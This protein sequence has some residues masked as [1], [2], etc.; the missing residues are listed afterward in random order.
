MDLGMEYEILLLQLGSLSRKQ[1]HAQEALT[2]HEQQLEAII[3]QMEKEKLD[4]EK[5]ERE[6]LSTALRKLLGTFEKTYDRESQDL[7]RAKLE[8]DKAYALKVSV[9]R[10]LNELEAEIIEKKNRLRSVKETLLRRNPQLLT[11]G[12]R[13]DQALAKLEHEYTQIQEAEAAG[14][15]TLEAITDILVT[16]DSNDTITNWELITEIDLILNY[17]NKEQLNMAEAMILH[18]EK[19]VSVLERE[20]RDVDFL[21]EEQYATISSSKSVLD[22][23]LATIFQEWSKKAII[24]K[25]IHHLKEL[26]E[27]VLQVMNMLAER[28]RELEESFLE[29]QQ[30]EEAQQEGSA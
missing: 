25:S 8:F 15:Q 12:D 24:E 28:K 5:L 17:V 26:E 14:Y 19:C 29:M 6:S 21:Y 2:K 18:L 11:A 20:L 1:Y 27:N 7:V 13:A 16:L 4:L 10:Q 23:F 3:K 9:Q 22:D 30:A